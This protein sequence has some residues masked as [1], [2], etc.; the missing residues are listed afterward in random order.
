M[1]SLKL[2]GTTVVQVVSLVTLEPTSTKYLVNGQWVDVF[3]SSA[4]AKKP[5]FDLDPAKRWG[6]LTSQADVNHWNI[7]PAAQQNIQPNLPQ[8]EPDGPWN[9]EVYEVP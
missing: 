9:A 4:T 7:L 1:A 6:V 8:T 2:N 5:N 3:D